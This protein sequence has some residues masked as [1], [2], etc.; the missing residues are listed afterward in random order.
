MNL[1]HNT[2]MYLKYTP[3]RYNSKNNF[4]THSSY[5]IHEDNVFT[6]T[7]S[8]C[9]I[10]LNFSTAHIS[11]LVIIYVIKIWNICI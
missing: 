8:F 9:D 6:A 2:L 1:K 3:V 5:H 10:L 7:S 11:V 4:C